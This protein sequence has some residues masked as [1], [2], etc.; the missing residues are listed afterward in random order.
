[1]RPRSSAHNMLSAKA[2]LAVRACYTLKQALVKCVRQCYKL[3][4]ASLERAQ[5]AKC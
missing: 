1:M 5:V 4:K 2:G 3:N